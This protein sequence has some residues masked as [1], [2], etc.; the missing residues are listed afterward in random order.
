MTMRVA[1]GI[2]LLVACRPATKQSWLRGTSSEH[3]ASL[4]PTRI[5]DVVVTRDE[6]TFDFADEIIESAVPEREERP[7]E[8]VE[9]LALMREAATCIAERDPAFGHLWI[10]VTIDPAGRAI[11]VSHGGFGTAGPCVTM[12]ARNRRYRALRETVRIALP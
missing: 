6:Q 3:V 2:V 10:E 5:D 12:L 7:P 4:H 1:L 11:H 9:A 8:Q